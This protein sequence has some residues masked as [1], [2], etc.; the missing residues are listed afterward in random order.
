MGRCA[1]HAEC[2]DRRWSHRQGEQDV[3]LVA[4][5]AIVDL[6]AF[7][8]NVR[9]LR[10]VVRPA[11]LMVVL[12]A[13]AYGHG[14]A[15]TGA[16]AVAAGARWLGVLDIDS[17]L[18]LRESGIDP[19]IRI[20]AWQYLPDQRF[21]RAV[22][23]DI[24]LG[25]S[26]ITE[27]EAV[28]AAAGAAPARI[29]LK[30]DTGLMRNGATADDWPALVVAARELQARRR[31][32]IVGIWTHLAEASED[33]DSAA[34]DRFVAAVDVAAG[35]GVTFEFRHLAAS[36]A[37]F[38]RDDVRFD[39]VRMGGHTWGIPSFDGVTA[40]DMG[41]IPVM[42][43]R[44]EVTAVKGDLAEVP[45]GYADGVP[46]RAAG[47]L[48]VA[49]RGR[50]RRIR[51]VGIDY[52]VIEDSADVAVGDEVTLFGSGAAGEQTVREWGDLT[53]TLGDEIVTR[54][55]SRVARR[56]VGDANST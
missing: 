40:S 3:G 39:M 34:V 30:I 36:S 26:T 43:L 28:A 32:A 11:E 4:S 15:E 24:D 29:H 33:A 9:H 55:S 14:V 8:H 31:V 10:S 13:N 23:A 6:G 48:D 45:L 25:V 7:A 22:Q 50:R 53:Q 1:Q 35:L 20:M 42:T 51:S 37:G 16:A 44:S 17:A 21:D 52:V 54:I 18:R 56:Y 38:R 19:G 27:L 5:E 41:L 49:I 47:L 2:G 12:K 46:V